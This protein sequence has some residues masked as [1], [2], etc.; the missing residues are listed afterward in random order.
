MN[1][2]GLTCEDCIWSAYEE[3]AFLMIPM[4]QIGILN[5]RFPYP[6]SFFC[7]RPEADDLI[8]ENWIQVRLKE[9]YVN[10]ERMPGKE[11]AEKIFKELLD[12]LNSGNSC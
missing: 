4:C 8:V 6:C 9:F 2:E 5:E 10:H 1:R 11:E 7:E 12:Y 3:M